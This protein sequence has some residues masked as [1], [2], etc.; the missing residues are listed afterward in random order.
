MTTRGEAAKKQMK[1]VECAGGG[2][3][4]C[5]EQTTVSSSEGAVVR[6]RPT[7]SPPVAA[8][9]NREGV[10]WRCSCGTL[11]WVCFRPVYGTLRREAQAKGGC[12]HYF[13]PP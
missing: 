2:R 3:E 7:R 8:V 5:T 1:R 9:G 6:L 4:Y 13:L 10:I 12:E 11:T